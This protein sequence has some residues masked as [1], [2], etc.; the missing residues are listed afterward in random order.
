LIAATSNRRY[1]SSPYFGGV[2]GS[3]VDLP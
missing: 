2:G 1:G 3:K